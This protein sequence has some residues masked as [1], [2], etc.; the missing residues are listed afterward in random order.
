MFSYMASCSALF[1]STFE[2]ASVICTVTEV[3]VISAAPSAIFFTR[4]NRR[5]ASGRCGERTR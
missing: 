2:V 3:S 5:S 4:S 1:G